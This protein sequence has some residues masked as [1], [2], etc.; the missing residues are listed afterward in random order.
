MDE[1]IDR[2]P[3]IS[4]KAA[5]Q[6]CAPLRYGVFHFPDCQLLDA[7]VRPLGF[8]DLTHRRVVGYLRVVPVKPVVA[9]LRHGLYDF[10]YVGCFVK[11]LLGLRR[12]DNPPNWLLGLEPGHL[13]KRF[14]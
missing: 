9:R 13:I 1:L 14:R 5:A 2:Q 6:D 12:F 8:D 7:R 11:P 4:A 10:F 3:G